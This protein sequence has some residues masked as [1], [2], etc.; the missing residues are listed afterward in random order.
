M[1]KF[2][3][4]L[5]V[6]LVLGGAAYFMFVPQMKQ[7]SY[8]SGFDAG[9]KK[10]MVTGTAAGITQGMSEAQ[11]QQKQQHDSVDAAAK[12]QAVD[13]AAYKASHKPRMAKPAIQN[14]HVIHG[15]IMDPVV[16]TSSSK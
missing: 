15:K 1:T 14:W 12:K 2:F 4:G 10:G 3:I 9:N 7:T 11:T 5:L 6:G 8:D 13:A 16:D